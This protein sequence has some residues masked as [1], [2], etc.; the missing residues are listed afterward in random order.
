MTHSLPYDYARS[1]KDL[2]SNNFLVF[3]QCIVR[4][5]NDFWFQRSSEFLWNLLKAQDLYCWAEVKQT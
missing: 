2:L 4:K 5:I 3:L 1:R